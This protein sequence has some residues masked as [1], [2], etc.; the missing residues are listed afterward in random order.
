MRIML[1]LIG[2]TMHAV[3]LLS[4]EPDITLDETSKPYVCEYK[5]LS[6]GFDFDEV[7]PS[8]NISNA[9][10]T[11]LEMKIRSHK[12]KHTS[13][14]YSFGT[15]TLGDAANRRS[16]KGQRDADGNVDTDT[17]V[18]TNHPDSVDISFKIQRPNKIGEPIPKL[19]LFAVSFSNTKIVQP[20]GI[21]P[22]PAWGK[23]IEVPQRAQGNYPNGGVLCSPTSLSMMLWHYAIQL[24]RPELN[25]DVP[26]VVSN[27]WDA[28][29][30]GAGN[31]PYN[32]AYA[33]SFPGIR[34]YVTRFRSIEDLETWIAAGLPVI[35]SISLGTAEGKT[36][37]GDTGHLVVLVGFTSNGDPIFNDPARK[38]QVRYTYTRA[39]F[40][41]AWL[42]SHRTV[43][44][45]HPDSIHPPKSFADVWIN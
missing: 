33:G 14:W 23:T 10:L 16:V 32:T 5:N 43:Y 38:Q 45:V 28:T 8:W 40:E 29:Y 18:A 3:K 1:A 42:H 22:S 26:E 19:T 36:E 20:S 12:G 13:K 44:L 34:A 2:L 4:F 41:K 7:I 35:C 9:G 6:P 30:D 17:F 37:A 15:W 39:H 25:K 11:T 24:G 27:V 31:W 21:V